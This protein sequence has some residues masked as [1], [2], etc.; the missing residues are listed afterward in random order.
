VLATDGARAVALV[1][2]ER[3]FDTADATPA[4]LATWTGLPL[5]PAALVA[6]L[7]G[8]APCPAPS[9][10]DAGG[11]GTDP[12][13]DLRFQPSGAAG[14]GGPDCSGTLYTRPGGRVL[15]T[16]ECA[17]GEAGRW[18]ERIRVELPSS[19][20][21]IELRRTGG[22][23]AALLGDALFAPAIPAGFRH[24]D[25]LTPTDSESLLE[26]DRGTQ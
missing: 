14:G 3:R 6:L 9:T 5:G 8:H 7:G 23:A 4:A 19:G 10:V 18:P 15:A 26:G 11:A 13:P 20:R 25:L 22:P 24:S 16:I 21:S 2:P 12:C 1:V 17:V